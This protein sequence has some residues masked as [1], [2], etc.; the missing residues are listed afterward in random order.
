MKG[1]KLDE[2]LREALQSLRPS[3]EDDDWNRLADT[4][5]GKPDKKRGLGWMFT[6]TLIVAAGMLLWLM[7]SLNTDTRK[8][9]LLQKEAQKVT[10]SSKIKNTVGEPQSQVTIGSVDY[11]QRREA[12]MVSPSPVS[13]KNQSQQPAAVQNSG[14]PAYTSKLTK[15]K[16]Q[17]KFVYTP[18]VIAVNPTKENDKKEI[19]TVSENNFVSEP[20]TPENNSAKNL[21]K[22][23]QDTIIKNK[24]TLPTN[25]TANTEKVE[26]SLKN[27]K[28][29]SAINFTDS[30]IAP[31]A[32]AKKV[33]GESVY[34]K[35]WL[36]GIS[37]TP[38]FA[39]RSF[40][41]NTS[42]AS[43]AHK[44]YQDIRN[45][46]DKPMPSFAVNVYAECKISASLGFQTGVSYTQGG[47]FADYNYK[48]TE[49]P[50]RDSAT[51]AILGYVQVS[52]SA[53]THLSSRQSFSY[54][55]IPFLVGYSFQVAPKWR[56]GIRA[57]GSIQKLQLVNATV[58]DPEALTLSKLS[59]KDQRV[60]SINYSYQLAL[61]V[62]YAVK[63]KFYIMAEP[64]FKKSIHPL[65]NA[66][67]LSRETLFSYGMNLG[68]MYKLF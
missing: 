25:Q 55:E 60:R 28:P 39:F 44:N 68:I 53:G 3:V 26:D 30:S 18:T 62:Y 61:G 32:V 35:G 22:A 43:I 41:M 37:V 64:V 51:H 33:T 20:K 46:Q 31:A 9:G 8:T 40:G 49:I 7:P 15:S 47:Y 13:A 59:T 11:S 6:T 52:D 42:K 56:M 12:Q 2:I 14:D 17:K 57:G 63:P 54:V 23:E 19:A 36:V 27:E 45:G 38:Q 34:G 66:T 48:V 10:S 67:S 65:M 24:E 1:Q 29:L 16:R 50:V 58:V 21:I 5:D 4:L